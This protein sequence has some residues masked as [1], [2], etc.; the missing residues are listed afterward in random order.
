MLTFGTGYHQV[1][2]QHAAK[3]GA[4]ELNIAGLLA[5]RLMEAGISRV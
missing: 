2:I 5:D 3:A 4:V 1:I